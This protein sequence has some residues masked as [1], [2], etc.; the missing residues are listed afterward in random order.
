MNNTN[1]A[2]PVVVVIG[3]M[4]LDIVATAADSA[5]VD[6]STPGTV[7]LVAGG[8]GRNIA[9]GLSRLSVNSRFHSLIGQDLPGD[10]VM[11]LSA[12]AGLATNRVVRDVSGSTPVYVSMNDEHGGML[13]AISDMAL[14]D[15]CRPERFALLASDLDGAELCIVDSNMPLQ[16]I[17]WI[18]DN[19]RD[20][21]VVAEAVSVTKCERL[22]SV[23]PCLDMIKVN[24]KEAARLVSA[25]VTVEPEHLASRLLATGVQSVLITLGK[26]GVLYASVDDSKVVMQSRP[27]S[28]TQINGVNGAGDSLLA[29]FLAARLYGESIESQLTW[30]SEAARLS[31]MSQNACSERLSLN[32]LQQSSL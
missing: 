7:Q 20:T 22:T 27:S 8:V 25:D 2:S 32:H 16:V 17:Q 9:E 14:L 30:G 24:R 1:S 5:I 6:D 11:R 4:S 3:A 23:L 12:D 19:N 10:Q 21:P 29:G 31:L 13:H 28:A 15:E 26:C 18:V